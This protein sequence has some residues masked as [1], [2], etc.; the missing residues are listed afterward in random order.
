[1]R[2]ISADDEDFAAAEEMVYGL[3]AEIDICIDDV[4]SEN[5]ELDEQVIEHVEKLF[6][7]ATELVSSGSLQANDELR[8]ALEIRSKVFT[9]LFQPGW[10]GSES[11]DSVDERNVRDR[12]LDNSSDDHVGIEMGTLSRL[13]DA[14]SAS[15]NV[16]LSL[17]RTREALQNASGNAS[18]METEGRE[19]RRTL[20]RISSH[21]HDSCMFIFILL[22]L[23]LLLVIFVKYH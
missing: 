20:N 7:Q 21:S 18:Q 2:S 15:E 19:V 4:Q 17:A 11:T 3:F 14:E 12:L 22:I 5:T 1:M 10:S 13:R 8:E 9:N 23:L 16:L 6:A